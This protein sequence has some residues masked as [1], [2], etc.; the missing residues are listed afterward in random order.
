MTYEKDDLTTYV[1]ERAKSN[2]NTSLIP[3]YMHGG[4]L[5]WLTNAIEP[6]SF[7]EAIFKN[8]L[9]GA[10]RAADHNNIVLLRNYVDYITGYLPMGCQGSTE[11]YQEWLLQGGLA[12][13]KNESN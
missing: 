3:E 6:G 7:L 4:I 13:G 11:T 2:L 8:D 10:V 9:K 1:L 12:G 5:R